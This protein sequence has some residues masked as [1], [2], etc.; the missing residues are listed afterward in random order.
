MS[1]RNTD[2]PIPLVRPS[3][4]WVLERLEARYGNPVP[5]AI[6][7]PLDELIAC[8]LS[9]HTSDRNSHR[10]FARLKELFPDWNQVINAPTDEVV[11]AIWDGGL[12]HSKAP[13]IQA[14]L[15]EIQKREGELCLNSLTAMSDQEAR[16]YL[17]GLPGVGPKTA[18]IVLCF[19]LGR[20]VIPV[21][22]HVF[23]VAHRIGWIE[24][25][26][27]EGRAHDVL[28]ELVD[29]GNAYRLHIALI[30]H[31]RQICKAHRPLCEE[32]PLSTDCLYYN[33][34]ELSD[35]IK[36]RK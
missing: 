15:R 18:A 7:D 20:S 10:T 28:Q 29:D 17:L 30:R 16:Q 6:T 26:I 12:A 19:A 22:T 14:V 1:Q 32:C 36:V 5:P 2:Y 31:G 11:D 4:D 13:R 3:V 34:R 24:Q 21:D 35:N 9:Q 33:Q 27:G 25:R 23:R 8:I